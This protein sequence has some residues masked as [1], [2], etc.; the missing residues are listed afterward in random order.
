[1]Y[2][3]FLVDPGQSPEE[4]KASFS[5]IPGNFPSEQQE[6]YEGSLQQKR[7]LNL[8]L[9]LRQYKLHTP[10]FQMLAFKN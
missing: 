6:H 4:V 1:M 9:K 3:V 2:E 7:D 8:V 5:G 10:Q